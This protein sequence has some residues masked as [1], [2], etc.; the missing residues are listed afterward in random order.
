MAGAGVGVRVGDREWELQLSLLVVV[1]S[2]VAVDWTL[3]EA[4]YGKLRL[5]LC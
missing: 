1:F 4:F 5:W 3:R 2:L